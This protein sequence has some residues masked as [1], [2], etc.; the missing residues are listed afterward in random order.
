MGEREVRSGDVQIWTEEFGRSGD[1]SVLLIMG[2]GRQGIVW[3]DDFC[4]GLGRNGFH[5]IRYDHRDTGRSSVAD[6][7][8]HPY[9]LKD[10]ADDSVAV[11]DGY[12]IEKVHII[13]LSMG[14][15][16]GQLLALNAP[17]RVSTLTLISTSPDQGIY[18]AATAGQDTSAYK[19]S[20][21]SDAVLAYVRKTLAEPPQTREEFIRNGVEGWRVCAGAGCQFDEQAM[22]RLEE[23][24]FSRAR[25]PASAWNH[26]R[27]MAIPDGRSPRLRGILAPVLILHG[28]RDPVL[29]L[30]HGAALRAAVPGS[31]LRIILGWG[32]YFPPDLFDRVMPHILNHLRGKPVGDGDA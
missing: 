31:C 3:P 22:Y 6:C 16:I 14:G 27:A 12:G 7:E 26:G 1:P 32:H 20:R 24:V 15:F 19:L 23:H 11:L 18:I 13:G 5:T 4:L 2:A 10:L 30:D 25:N 21:P 28:E 9:S 17:S 8:A 29:P